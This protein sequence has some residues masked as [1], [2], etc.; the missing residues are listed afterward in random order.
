MK[1]AILAG[2]LGTRMRPLTYTRPKPLLPILN[3]PMLRRTMDRMPPEV[4]GVVLAV[5]YLADQIRGYLADEPGPL[6][7][8]VVEEAEPL[9]TGGAVKN[10]EASLGGEPFFVMNGDVVSDADLGAMLAAH[11]ERSARGTIH[12]W[13]VDDPSRYGVVQLAPDGRIDAFIEKP[14]AGQAPSNLI[15]AGT[16]VLEPSVLELI[17]A[18]RPVSM[19]REVF[20][21]LAGRGLYSFRGG[22][23]WVDAGKPLDYLEA[24]RLLMRAPGGAGPATVF[25]GA[26]VEPPVLIPRTARVGPRAHVG[27]FVAAGERAAIGDGARV[28]HSVLLPD[29]VVGPDAVVEYA[30]IGQGAT[31]GQGARLAPGTVVADG[32]SV[33]PGR[34]TAPDEKVPAPGGPV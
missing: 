23:L 18:G 33:E 4:D 8:E 30:V 26:Q 2:G 11:R 21:Q 7:V 25:P 34:V 31:V 17:P 10:L 1:A 13:P 27:P 12:V 20:P 5:N 22:S 14:P 16:Y 19:E 24:H 29:A 6:P 9:G 15:N 32:A 3:V 28:S